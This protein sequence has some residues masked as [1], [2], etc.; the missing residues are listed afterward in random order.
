MYIATCT[1][2]HR[3]PFL[4]QRTVRRLLAEGHAGSYEKAELAAHLMNFSF[5]EANSLQAAEECSSI[6]TA[7]QFL[8]QECELCAEKYPMGKVLW[9]LPSFRYI[10][11][12]S[13]FFRSRPKI[14][15]V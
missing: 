13:Y 7:L 4:L 10:F 12:V 6:Y 2:F 3:H 15:L 5:D 11:F 14:G 1:P 8:Q 9:L